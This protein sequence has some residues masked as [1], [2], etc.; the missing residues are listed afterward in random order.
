MTENEL[1]KI[2]V[3]L[4]IKSHRILGPGLLESV[5]EAALAHRLKKL[6]IRVSNQ[7]GV[8]LIYD[9]LSMD[10][11]FRADVAVEDKVIIEIKSIETILP[12]TRNNCLLI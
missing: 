10:V 7:A 11:G 8:P 9:D 6:G 3:D 4:C 12:V 2:V 1:A 5:H